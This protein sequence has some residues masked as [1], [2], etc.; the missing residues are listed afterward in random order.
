MPHDSD[1]RIRMTGSITHDRF[2]ERVDF[3]LELA[4]HLHTSGTS[5]NRLEGAVERVSNKLGLQ[6]SIWSNPTGFIISF[7]DPVLG[8]PHT[9]TR[10]MRLKPGDTHL[11]RLSDADAIAEQ[12]MAGML[13]IT[14]GL[15]RLKAMDREPTR[16]FRI[17]TVLCFGIASAMVV[18]LFPRTGWNDFGIAALL[19][20]MI[21]LLAQ[22]GERKPQLHDAVEAV[23]AFL[24]T[25]AASLIGC[26]L[27]PL[28]IQPVVISALIIMMPGMMLT[29]AINELANQQLVSG[30][31]RFA[32]AMTVLMK[33]TFGTILAAQLVQ[34]SGC[35]L[36]SNAGSSVL[37]VWMPW[38]MVLP[39]SFALAVLFK[40]HPRDIPIAMAAVLL[41]YG[42][43]KVCALVPALTTGDIPVSAF[44]AAFTVT[45][46]SNL[47]AR[48]FNR[49]GALIRVPGIILLV[50]GSLGYRTLNIAFAQDLASSLDL[51]FSLFAALIALVAGILFGNLLVS[52]RRYL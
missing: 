13:D 27:V 4:R 36:L 20:M 30:S 1:I 38:V 48:I 18:S 44:L 5:V 51:A 34:I 7:Q 14:S 41:G 8:P 9:V 19:G 52:S 39:G 32:G 2:R 25:L 11:G 10:V 24:V 21:G 31:A 37:P 50:P 46:V 33:L 12:V 45:A 49:P 3:V 22:S 23:A 42:V 35:Q 28:S 43:I 47:Y 26:F 40:T 15:S 16:L 29:S 6:V 17:A